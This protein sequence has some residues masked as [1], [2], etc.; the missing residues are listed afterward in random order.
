MFVVLVTAYCGVGSFADYSQLWGVS[1]EKW[2]PAGRLDDYSYAGYR[3]GEKAIPDSKVV[4]SVK[5]FGAIGDGVADDSDAFLAAIASVNKGA[6][7]IPAG[8]YKITKIIEIKKSKVVLRGEGPDKTILFFPKYLNDIKPNWGHTTSGRP[9][10]NYSWSGGF[11]WFKGNYR[12]KKLTDITGPAKRGDKVVTVKSTDKIKPGDQIEIFLKDKPDNSFAD[13]L[14]CGDPGNKSKLNGR[15]K[16]SIVCTVTVVN[17]NKVSFNRPLRFDIQTQWTPTVKSF[18]PSLT[19][20]GIEELCFEFPTAPYKGHF[21]ELGY[22][23]IA[24]GKAVHCWARNIRILDCDSG[25]FVN[26]RFCT[27]QNIVYDT[28]R[29]PDKQRKSHGHHGIYTSSDDNL[30][31][32]FRFNFPFIHD[33]TVSHCAGNVTSDGSGADI[34]FDHHKCAPY[35]NLFTNIDIGKGTRMFRCGGGA[36]LGRNSAAYTTFW[37]IRANRPQ[38]WPKSFGPDIMNFVAVETDQPSTI[39]PNGRWFEAIPPA[40]IHPQDI[41]KAQLKK[42]TGN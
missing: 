21:T 32:D 28:N 42:R 39:P 38:K 10:S 22:N 35:S 13:H 24:F 14:Y 1:G 19:D 31:T 18:N 4:C 27:V 8:K 3:S 9:T 7:F 40:G 23:A 34:C 20:S 25:I 16:A 2:D 26:S 30:F 5:D 33:I 11:I 12:S 36:D 6:I 41:H 37:N 15:T 17:G 29:K